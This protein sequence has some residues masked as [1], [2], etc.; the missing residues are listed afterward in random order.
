MTSVAFSTSP[1]G[2]ALFDAYG[3]RKPTFSML[4]HSYVAC[5]GVNGGGSMIGAAFQYAMAR[6]YP[7][8][9]SFKN[10]TAANGGNNHGVGGTTINSML[11]NQLPL[12]QADPTDVA[13]I[14]SGYNDGFGTM[15]AVNA[16]VADTITVSDACIVAG[17]KLVIIFGMGPHA[18]TCAPW[19]IQSYNNMLKAYAANTKGVIYVDLGALWVDASPATPSTTE[20]LWKGGVN[21]VG[22][23]SFDGVH[24]SG[25]ALRALAPVL[26]PIL[27]MIARP[28]QPR[29][30]VPCGTGG[31]GTYNAS[32]R[33][34][35]NIFGDAGLMCSNGIGG[36]LNGT[37]NAN[38]VGDCSDG[39]AYFRWD[40]STNGIAVT[41][42]IVTGADGFRRQRLTFSG[43]VSAGAY[44]IFQSVLENGSI[45]NGDATRLYDMEAMLELNAVTGLTDIQLSS[46]AANPTANWNSAADAAHRWP[47]A[48]SET[49]FY[50]Q[51]FPLTIPGSN[52]TCRVALY[53]AGG[54]TA[55][56]SIDISRVSCL[57][58][59]P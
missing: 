30:A 25:T 57:Q 39:A 48:T 15:T 21:A 2:K 24:P 51:T 41:P 32:T 20:I 29:A 8:D 9:I 10:L 58:V 31:G 13:C 28:R 44:V 18:P 54:A 36:A 55:A 33:S 52:P 56:G 47:D 16:N 26:D 5:A 3:G 59:A 27:R 19:G 12:F 34:R 11:V 43:T 37:A 50:Y 45:N 23:Y 4:G 35:I 42:T 46:T 40:V 22:A 38:V 6:Y 53:F 49:L 7:A 1:F 14:C 17:A